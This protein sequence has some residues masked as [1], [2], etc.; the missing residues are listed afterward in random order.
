MFKF[1][2]GAGNASLRQPASLDPV[3]VPPS[4][5]D[6]A[7]KRERREHERFEFYLDRPFGE[8]VARICK[9]L[10]MKPDWAAWACDASSSRTPAARS[11]RP[12]SRGPSSRSPTI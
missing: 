6:P 11:T 8:V 2:N 3:S 4:D 9:G 7:E 10:G 12:S 5:R 1:T